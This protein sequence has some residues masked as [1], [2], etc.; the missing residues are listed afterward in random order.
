MNS[1]RSDVSKLCP[2][3]IGKGATCVSCMDICA[4]R[5]DAE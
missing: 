3:L 1:L 4:V 5:Q 2:K